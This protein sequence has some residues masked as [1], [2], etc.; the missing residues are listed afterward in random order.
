MPSY[1][2]IN[3]LA[4]ARVEDDQ[5]AEDEAVAMAMCILIAGYIATSAQL[6]KFMYALQTFLI[7]SL[8]CVT[9]QSCCPRR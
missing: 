6:P 5:F 3:A 1:D 4:G 8:C 7:S 9:N 2:L